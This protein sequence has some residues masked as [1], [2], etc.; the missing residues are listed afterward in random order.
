MPTGTVSF[1][2]LTLNKSGGYRLVATAT[3]FGFAAPGT[4]TSTAFHVGQ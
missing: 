1:D 3:L 2:D 4:A